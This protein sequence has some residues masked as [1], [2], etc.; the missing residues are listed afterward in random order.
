MCVTGHA[1]LSALVRRIGNEG[2][3]PTLAELAA[4]FAAGCSFEDVERA[5]ADGAGDAFAE[6][7]RRLEAVRPP[8]AL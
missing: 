7:R 4:L 5:L 3:R 6:A 1:L 8:S 2:Y